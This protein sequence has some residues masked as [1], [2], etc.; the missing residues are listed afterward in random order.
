MKTSTQ[1]SKPDSLSSL[2]AVTVVEIDDPTAVGDAVEV[3][4]QDVVQLA[5]NRLRVYRVTVRLGASVVLYQSTNLPVRTRTKLRDGFVAYVTFGPRSVGTLNG[6]PVGPD[7]V[8]A[9]K[10]GVEVEFVVAAGYESVSFL[11]SP[12]DIRIHLRGR[13]LEDEFRIPN[14]VELLTP[15][16]TAAHRLYQWG[17]QLTEIAARQPEIFELPQTQSTAQVELLESLLAT[18]RATGPVKETPH[19]LTRQAHSQVVQIAENYAL[20][21]IA[22][23]LYVTDLCEAAGVSERTLQYAFK[24]LMGT[25][26][27]A[28]LTRLRLH[29]VRQ[30]LRAGTQGTTTVTAEAMRWG[31][32][33]F[34]GFSRAYKEC[35]GELPSDTLRRPSGAG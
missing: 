12:D 13:N 31:F 35:F 8:L 16:P 32:W 6:M 30:A 20:S 26:P 9:A 22:D 5:S 34:G 15:C 25:S 3:I 2:S 14:G 11:L 1:P 17:R 10:P 28:Y 24:E 19:D 33:H 21:H 29:R 27:V 4:E 7:R 18:L 23:G